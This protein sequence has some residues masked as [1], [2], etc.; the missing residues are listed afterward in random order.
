M[1]ARVVR[2][3]PGL[4]LLL[5]IAAPAMLIQSQI[6][7]SGRTVV[8]AVAI[9]IVIGVLLRNLVGLPE[10]CKPGVTLAVKRLLR[11]GIALLG[12]QLSLGQV[13]RTGGKAVWG[14]NVSMKWIERPSL[15]DG[16]GPMSIQC[17]VDRHTADAN[18]VMQELFAEARA[19]LCRTLAPLAA[20]MLVI[21]LYPQWLIDTINAASVTILTGIK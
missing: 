5:A 4:A 13:L 19:D 10:A 20:L 18:R 21:G 11:V 16:C 14:K 12:A 3:L 15:Y 1:E 8:S 2:H 17:M 7:V 6:T 9:A